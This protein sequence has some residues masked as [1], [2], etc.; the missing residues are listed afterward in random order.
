MNRILFKEVNQKV[1]DNVERS[2]ELRARQCSTPG[3]VLPNRLY[4]S[5]VSGLN[6]GEANFALAAGIW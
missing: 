5:A 4:S 1:V 3:A 2:R 6:K